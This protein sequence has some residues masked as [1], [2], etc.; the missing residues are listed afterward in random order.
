LAKRPHMRSWESTG[1]C[2]EA[3]LT[4]AV[5]RAQVF[6]SVAVVEERV[7]PVIATMNTVRPY[8]AA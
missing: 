6:F 5:Q 8:A 4:P 1:H 2:G 7:Q 3:P